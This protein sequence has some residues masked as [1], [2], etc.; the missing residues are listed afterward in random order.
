MS[1]ELKEYVNFPKNMN[2]WF[3]LWNDTIFSN[4]VSTRWSVSKSLESDCFY[5]TDDNDNNDNN[6]N[7]DDDNNNDEDDDDNNYNSNIF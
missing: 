6:N 7:N 4:M 2:L 3:L 5:N 1:C